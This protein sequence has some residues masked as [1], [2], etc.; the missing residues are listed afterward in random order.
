MVDVTIERKKL[1][2]LLGRLP[3]SC[4]DQEECDNCALEGEILTEISKE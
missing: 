4:T 3:C 1:L 2:D